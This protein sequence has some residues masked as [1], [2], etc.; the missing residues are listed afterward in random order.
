MA[1]ENARPRLGLL[2]RAFGAKDDPDP[3]LELAE[4]EIQSVDLDKAS[5][6]FTI[7]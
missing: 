3:K 2:K 1:Y 4:G 5:H 7:Y 6:E